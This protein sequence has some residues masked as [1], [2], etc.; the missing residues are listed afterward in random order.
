MDPQQRLLMEV[1]YEAFHGGGM[2]KSSLSG[3]MSGVFVGISLIDFS[4]IVSA[5]PMSRSVYAATGSSLSIA[6]GRLSFA[7]GLQGPCASYDTAC[8]AALL[9]P[10]PRFVR[11]S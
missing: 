10:T 3:L 5:S 6:S 7:L 11:S 9:P 1:G 2:D 8:S 4:F